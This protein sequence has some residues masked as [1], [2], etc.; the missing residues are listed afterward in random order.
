MDALK[1]TG[2]PVAFV[3]M[4]KMLSLRSLSDSTPP[5][6]MQW[7]WGSHPT[8]LERVSLAKSS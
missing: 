6:V 3:E 8:T 4:Q 2:D 5:A 7:W 1:A